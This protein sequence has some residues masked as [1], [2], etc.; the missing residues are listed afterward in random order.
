MFI[1]CL[2]FRRCCNTCD[3]V[4][5]AYRQKGWAFTNSDEI[6]QCD[7]EKWNDKIKVILYSVIL[8]WCF[9]LV[10]GQQRSY[11]N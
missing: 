8:K 4:R 10:F 9:P 7:R 6:E 11:H 3:D 5:E 1:I 2:N